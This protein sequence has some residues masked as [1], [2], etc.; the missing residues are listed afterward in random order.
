MSSLMAN[1]EKARA[2]LEKKIQAKAAAALTKME[3]DKNNADY[4]ET[5]FQ[6][7]ASELS[8]KKLT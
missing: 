4:K 2:E 6:A 8:K 1:K 3:L 7:N 5:K